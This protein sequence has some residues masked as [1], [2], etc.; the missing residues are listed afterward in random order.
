MNMTQPTAS[1][2]ASRLVRYRENPRF[3]IE[4][5]FY[6][7]DRIRR[8]TEL[9]HFNEAQDEL[10]NE[11]QGFRDR[12]R[13]VRLWICKSRRAGL[14]TGCQANIFHDTLFF[15]QTYSLIVA[16]LQATAENLL[17]MDAVFWEKLP[18]S[19]QPKLAPEY[20]GKPGKSEIYFSE[21]DQRI[22]TATAKNVEQALSYGYNNVHAT[23]VARWQAGNDLMTAIYPTLSKE[24]HSAFYGESTPLGQGN[25]FHEQCMLA[26]ESGGKHG[27]P[28]GGFRL[29]FIPWH[30]LKRSYAINFDT[31]RDKKDFG[32]TLD[33]KEKSLIALHTTSL[34]Q[35]NWRRSQ[36][37]GPPFNNDEDLFDQEY[38]TDLETAFLSSGLT[39]L[40]RDA[41]KTL[42]ANKRPP[43]WKGDIYWGR[44]YKSNQH[45]SDYD[46]VRR[47]VVLTPGEARV[48][49]GGTYQRFQCS[50]NDINYEPLWVYQW[51]RKGDRIVIACDVGGGNP[52]T[53]GGGDPSTIIVARQEVFGPSEVLMA[54]GGRIAP[55]EFARL[56]SALAWYVRDRTG[57]EPAPLLAPEWNGV[58]VPMNT[59]IDNRKLYEPH[60]RYFAPG[61]RGTP[62]S[63]HFGWESNSKTK[64]LA[65]G[66]LIDMIERNDF[67]I[68]D[69]R[70][71]LELS[72][73]KKFLGQ[74]GED[75]G[76]EGAHDDFVCALY[77][78]AAC[79]RMNR[80]GGE[81][82]PQRLMAAKDPDGRDDGEPFDFSNHSRGTMA[83]D[84]DS[85]EYEGG[86][87]AG[88][89][90]G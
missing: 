64:P 25:F 90:W 10:Q 72:A 67:D 56:A 9:L 85:M 6:F 73:Y 39:V 65:V 23:E 63:N 38:P 1:D 59:Y 33:D 79:I 4:N 70:C 49:V 58:G 34:E 14:S 8:R 82:A 30:T 47:P 36:L 84:D 83:N 18:K 80:I 20:H 5:L 11:I 24:P 69:S 37:A 31:P 45:E 17:E 44:D 76:G 81:A 35:L 40:S 86:S 2:L 28:Y 77:I 52:H 50:N 54:W 87:D 60:F 66:M 78:A 3:A 21:N 29:L 22:V 51:P 62:V 75:F 41:L 74:Q 42:V 43:K 16:N 53:K 15:P 89:D 26:A 19:M 12:R 88:M 55:V 57:D 27:G 71:V 68:P 7:R 13:P 46:L 32:Y 61:V 48:M